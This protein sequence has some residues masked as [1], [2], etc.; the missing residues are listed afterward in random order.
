[1]KH[2]RIFCEPILNPGRSVAEPRM[3]VSI[4]MVFDIFD[5]CYYSIKSAD[6]K[7]DNV[8]QR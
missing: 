1:M 3:C 4:L 5:G 2:R 8:W 6:K 7:E